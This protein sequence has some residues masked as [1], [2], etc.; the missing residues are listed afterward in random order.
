VHERAI[1]S[2]IR[3][4][5]RSGGDHCVA[6]LAPVAVARVERRETRGRHQIRRPPIISGPARYCCTRRSRGANRGGA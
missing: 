2:G 4:G 5:V 6:I 1:R 3:E